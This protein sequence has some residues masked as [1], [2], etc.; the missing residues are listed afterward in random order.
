MEIKVLYIGLFLIFTPKL[1]DLNTVYSQLKHTVFPNSFFSLD[2]CL[3]LFFM[4]HQNFCP[5]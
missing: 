5:K 2:L 1:S 4:S 3:I